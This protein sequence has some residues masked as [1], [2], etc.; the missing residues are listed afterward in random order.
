GR[1]RGRAH[2]A[3]DVIGQPDFAERGQKAVEQQHLLAVVVKDEHGVLVPGF[4]HRHVAR[5]GGRVG[6]ERLP[7]GGKLAQ[8]VVLI[9]QAP[10]AGVAAL[11]FNVLA[12][13]AV[14]TGATPAA[15]ATEAALGTVVWAWAAKASAT[16]SIV[17]TADLS[18][19]ADESDFEDDFFSPLALL[20]FRKGSSQPV[21]FFFK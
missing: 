9:G 17:R 13:G 8:V 7:G 18:D 3:I 2:G 19:W 15:G 1:E 12:V 14:S 10:A 11:G 4:Q 21:W 6:I 20:A 5:L 16:N